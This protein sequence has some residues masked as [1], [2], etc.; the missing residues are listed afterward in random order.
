MAAIRV[1]AP[2]LDW[3]S[4]KRVFLTGHT[5]FKG[6]WLSLWLDAIGARVTGYALAPLAGSLFEAADVGA[7]MVSVEGDVCDAERLCAALATAKPDIVIHMAAQ[8]LVRPSY[9]DAVGTFAT[10]VVGT[11]AL[12]EVVRA[13]P[14]I[15]ATVIVTSDKCYENEGTPEAFTE[16]HRMG[17][18]DPY[19]ASKGCAELVTTAFVRSFFAARPGSVVSARAGNVIGGGDWAVD[20]LVPDLM[21]G[22]RSGDAV[23]IRRPSAVRP[24]QHVLEPLRGYLMLAH[25]AATDSGFAGG[26]WNFG[27]RIADAV[28]VGEIAARIGD[29]WPQIRADI[30]HDIE[31]LAEAHSL[32]LDCTKAKLALDWQPILTLD[33][34]LDLTVDWY[35][36][37]AEGSDC[38]M[39]TRGQID[40]YLTRINHPQELF[41]GG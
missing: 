36:A 28:P 32:M 18:S 12:L 14:D 11:A 6:A 39:L 19:S 37:A 4:G 35:R 25:R 5:G 29:R 22:A 2:F 33:D 7:T 15:A 3:F 38:R 8:S 9:D 16:T 20:R 30:G 26:G 31:G 10:N 27:P 17:G 40:A 13:H 23:P 24:W 34:A 21:R 41:D 1:T